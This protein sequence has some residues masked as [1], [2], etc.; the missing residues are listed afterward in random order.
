MFMVTPNTTQAERLKKIF[1]RVR[2]IYGTIPTQM[3]F[4][5]NIDAEYLEAF[6]ANV[7]RLA[8]H[9]NIDFDLF[10]FLRLHV[11]FR[12]DYAFCKHYNTGFL[13]ARDFTQA[14]LD[15]AIKDIAAVPF[16]TRH[17]ALAQHAMRAIFEPGTVTQSD[18]DTLYAMGWSQ[19]D[20][21]DAVSHTGDL[22]KNGRILTAYTDKE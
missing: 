22:F 17:K 19:K 14:Q 15:A 20:V 21:F 16:D 18:L 10:G 3:E 9:P 6:I 7:L 13:L 4:L 1:R 12:E 8:R 2:A 5:G 11:A